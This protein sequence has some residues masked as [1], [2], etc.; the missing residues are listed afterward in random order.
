MELVSKL[1]GCQ[2]SF[3]KKII[4]LIMKHTMSIGMGHELQLLV[5][6]YHNF[7]KVENLSNTTVSIQ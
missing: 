3:G 1:H 6:Y 2:D 7:K 5:K 4:L